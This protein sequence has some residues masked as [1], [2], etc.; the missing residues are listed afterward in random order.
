MLAGG[1]VAGAAY[2][3]GALC[4]IDSL[5]DQGVQATPLTVNDFD[6]YVGTS[7]GAMVAA[8]LVNGIS[9]LMMLSLLDRPMRGM[10]P[11]VPHHLLTPNLTDMLQRGQFLPGSLITAIQRI[12]GG[13]RP[14][15]LIDLLEA[16]TA[17]LP[18]ALYDSSGLEL[19]LRDVLTQPDCSNDFRTLPH[20]LLITAANLNSGE[21]VI[22]G[23]PPLDTVPISTAVSASSA[24]PP[25]YRPVQVGDEIYIDGGIRGAASLDL[26]IE[27]GAELIF[28][29][30]PLVSFDNSQRTL[31][32]SLN[33]QGASLI[34]NQVF[35]TLLHTSM[36][37]HLEHM[38]HQYPHVDIILI[39]PERD[40]ALM[41][42]E[43]AMRYSARSIIARHGFETVACSLAHHYPTYQTLLAKHGIPIGTR[44]EPSGHPTP[45]TTPTAAHLSQ[46]LE[47]LERV[48]DHLETRIHTQ[49]I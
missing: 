7:A 37:H 30:N 1:G 23:L 17:S 12:F 49:P 8:S 27:H 40:D 28:C 9:P 18:T 20:T 25:F 6:L 2:E 22:F 44:P 36:L 24:L 11:F 19:F 46:T 41:F 14:D 38:R 3:I 21:R 35:R 16:L 31:G 10:N 43:H 39:E 26:A 42:S 5:L 15:S 34:G 47:E 32:K 13:I 33:D 48:L 45:Q 4:A 29:I